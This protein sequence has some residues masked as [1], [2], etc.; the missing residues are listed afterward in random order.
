MD[1]ARHSTGAQ[2][3]AAGLHLFGRDGFEATSTRAIAARA[4][5]NIS[6]IAYHFGGKDG[7][8]V[9]CADA[10]VAAIGQVAQAIPADPARIGR[11]QARL[12]LRRLMRRI[13][14]F[15]VTPAAQDSVGFLL[16]ELASPGS[17]VLD[18]IYA[19]LIEPRHRALCLL[20]AAATGGDPDS[21]DTRLA[22]FSWIGQAAYFRLA[23]PLVQRRMGWRGYARREARAILR[24]LLINLDAMLDVTDG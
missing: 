12:V 15:L 18:R 24:R 21:E 4:G 9:A 20:W 17:P 6:S 16:R 23:A 11:A 13:V 3:V 14:T 19:T 1:Q 8:R 22:V 7:L 5:T 2:L 10:V